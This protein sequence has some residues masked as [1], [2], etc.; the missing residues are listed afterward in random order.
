MSQSNSLETCWSVP[1]GSWWEGCTEIRPHINRKQRSSTNLQFM[2]FC[3]PFSSHSCS[4]LWSPVEKR[5]GREAGREKEKEKKR[6]RERERGERKTKGKNGINTSFQYYLKSVEY[7]KAYKIQYSAWL[8]PGIYG[9]LGSHFCFAGH[10]LYEHVNCLTSQGCSFLICRT[11]QGLKCL[12][13][14]IWHIEDVEGIC[15]E[16][17]YETHRYRNRVS[18][19]WRQN[20]SACPTYHLHKRPV[21]PD[22]DSVNEN[23]FL[24]SSHI[25]MCL[26]SVHFAFV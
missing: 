10:T 4:I 15:I 13:L 20:S 16:R 23:S 25:D 18:G 17:I 7:F 9:D 21:T 24:A 11:Q 12:H 14:G 3:R 8:R 22:R 26:L 5:R 19:M 6:E 1:A 2:L